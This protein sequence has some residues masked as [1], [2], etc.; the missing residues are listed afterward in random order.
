MAINTKSNITGEE[1]G[2][3][4]KEIIKK[5]DRDVKLSSENTGLRRTLERVQRGTLENT[6]KFFDALHSMGSKMLVETQTDLFGAPPSAEMQGQ[7]RSAGGL[8]LQEGLQERFS[9]VSNAVSALAKDAGLSGQYE[10]DHK[11]ITPVGSRITALIDA[12]TDLLNELNTN[13]NLAETGTRLSNM[14]IQRANSEANRLGAIR[15]VQT[16]LDG[17]RTARAHLAELENGTTPSEAQLQ[18]ALE[19][20]EKNTGPYNIETKKINDVN[21]LDSDPKLGSFSIEE[22][23]THAGKTGYQSKMGVVINKIME[24]NYGIDQQL[25]D[26]MQTS[27]DELDRIYNTVM[28]SNV[29]IIGSKGIENSIT[30]QMHDIFIGKK[31]KPTKSI[32]KSRKTYNNKMDL[33]RTKAELA[34]IKAKKRKVTQLLA[35]AAAKD[36]TKKRI[37]KSSSGQAKATLHLRRLINRRLPAEVRRNMGRPALI[38]RTGRFSNSVKLESL[39][40][41]KAG[42]VGKYSYMYRPYETFENTGRYKW[43][44]GYNPKPLITKSIRNLAVQHMETKLTLRRT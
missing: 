5:F 23:G 11:H 18:K 2:P 17:L 28:D 12:T 10:L 8:K 9:Y 14:G 44:T 13:P 35:A 20:N 34:K 40:P 38:N 36:K 42:M 6:K 26:D 43:P 16:R 33:R 22:T 19:A 15:E 7:A 24:G 21:V 31:H 25:K 39:V 41:S 29:E 30:K 4:W 1:R 32:T 37:R 3:E 27:D